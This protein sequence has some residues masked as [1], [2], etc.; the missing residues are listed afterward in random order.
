MPARR[1]A[2]GAARVLKALKRADFVPDAIRQSLEGNELGYRRTLQEAGVDE[3]AAAEMAKALVRLDAA[4]NR[5]VLEKA[6]R[7]A[8]IGYTGLADWISEMPDGRLFVQNAA[9]MAGIREELRKAHDLQASKGPEGWRRFAEEQEASGAPNPDVQMQQM[10]ARLVE[11]ESEIHDRSE[12]LKV[13]VMLHYEKKLG[14]QLNRRELFQT[15]RP[16]WAPDIKDELD[17][18]DTTEKL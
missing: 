4:G 7:L 18:D 16:S 15:W 3:K 9:K 13:L 12:R 11:L 5:H 1:S 2:A 17:M 8:N 6:V 14:R 10:S